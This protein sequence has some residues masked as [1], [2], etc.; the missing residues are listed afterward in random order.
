[1]KA[2]WRYIL[3]VFFISGLAGVSMAQQP[4]SSPTWDVTSGWLKDNIAANAGYGYSVTETVTYSGPGLASG[5]VD[6]TTGSQYIS[7]TFTPNVSC[8]LNFAV[9]D[10]VTGTA[11][12]ANEYIKSFDIDLSQ[13]NSNG[14][15]VQ[16]F[17][18]R[19]FVQQGWS[20]TTLKD[21]TD[22]IV[23]TP[24]A[25]SYWE[26]AGL[27]AVAMDGNTI[28]PTAYSDDTINVI[29]IVFTDQSMATRVAT[30]LNHAVDLCGG[31]PAPAQPF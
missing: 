31:K 19:N 29:P 28:S 24:A 14:I 12:D 22:V 17:D 30:A 25:A 5:S 8:H 10:R 6:T 20:F 18:L 2:I 27:V 26:I 16:P 15:K 7:F 9:N 21:Y 13:S 4:D 23:V 3:A 11:I 1:M